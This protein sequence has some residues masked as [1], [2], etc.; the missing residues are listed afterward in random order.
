MP[1]TLPQG[2]WYKANQWNVVGMM[3]SLV[4]WFQNIAK[5]MLYMVDAVQPC[6]QGLSSPYPKGSKERDPGSGWSQVLVTNFMIFMGGVLVYQNIVAS[7]VCHIQN[8]LSGQ[9]NGK[10][11]FDFHLPT[12]FRVG[13]RDERPWKQ[14]WI[15]W[16][17]KMAQI[18]NP[19]NDNPFKY[20]YS[21]HIKQGTGSPKTLLGSISIVCTTTQK[22]LLLKND[23]PG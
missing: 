11:C 1:S 19:R 6:S 2:K 14:G 16:C 13:C 22:Y 21:W 15:Q 18:W 20:L 17:F 23:L 8:R 7:S 4:W 10:L 12:P 3:D 5:Q 9:P